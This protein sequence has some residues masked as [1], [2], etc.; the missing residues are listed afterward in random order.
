VRYGVAV[1]AVLLAALGLRVG[2]MALTPGYT[3]VHDA[4]DYDVHARSIAAGDGFSVRLTGKQTAFRPPG[5]PYLLGG[6]YRAFGV[7]RALDPARI[8]VARA[9]GAVL[10]TLGVALIGLLAV[11]LAGRATGLIAMGLAAIYVPSILVSEAI[12]SEQLFVVLMLAALV[13]ALHQ[14]GSPHRYAFAVLAGVLAGLAVLTRANGL[15][16]LA[17][18]AL[19]VWAAP[20][21]SWRSLGPPVALVMVA[22]AVVAPWTVRNAVKLHAFVP[23]TT[24]LGWALAGTYNDEARDDPVN[25][26]SW[27]SLRRIEEYQPLVANFATVPEIVM[28][29]RL[30]KA[31]RAFVERHPTYVATVGYWNT[32]RLLDIASLKWSRHTASTISVTPGWAD[33]GVICF[34]IF[35]LL[36]LAGATLPAARRVPWFVWTMPA[37]MYLSVIF[38]AAETPRY[39]APLD[40][41]IVLLAAF[42]VSAALRRGTSRTPSYRGE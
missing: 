29:R 19:A 21:R 8:D 20:R 41:F 12:M 34:W 1:A 35:A 14:R 30:S 37:V 40:P 32:R 22:L 18:L 31:G 38:L 4:R 5:Y 28:E 23:V 33:A 15:I 17:P 26:G 6:V 2:Y 10:G 42:A 9:L 25:P 7:Q 39:R 24:Q 13:L 3:I 36:A 11:Q 16:L 27:R